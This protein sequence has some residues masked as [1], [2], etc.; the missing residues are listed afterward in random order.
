MRITGNG[1]SINDALGSSSFTAIRQEQMDEDVVCR[2]SANG[3]EAGITLYMDE[4][5]HYD[6]A[7]CEDE[8]GKHIIKRLCIGDIRHEAQRV[9]LPADVKDITVKIHMEPMLYHFAV[10]I[11]G[12]EKDLGSAQTRYLST[13]VTS[14]FTGV[15]I[16][17]YAEKDTQATFY[18]F[19]AVRKE[20]L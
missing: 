13:E 4:E 20:N 9:A 7:L 19:E 2:L 16:G 6:I 17:L 3:P 15:M 8:S 5:H 11:D 10:V 18:D 14:G 12:A 1:G